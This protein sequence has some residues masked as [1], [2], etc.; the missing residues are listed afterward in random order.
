MK[1]EFE[2]RLM[3]LHLMMQAQIHQID[4][5]SAQPQYVKDIKQWSGRYLRFIEPKINV[6][7]A[8]SDQEER[9]Y[10]QSFVQEIDALIESQVKRMRIEL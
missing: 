8:A 5:L 2:K 7:L 1:H 9:E 6:A 3:A 10:Y 4:E